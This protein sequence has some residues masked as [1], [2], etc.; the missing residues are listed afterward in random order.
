MSNPGIA[1]PLEVGLNLKYYSIL[2][3][4]VVGHAI[5]VQLNLQMITITLGLLVVGYIPGT[6]SIQLLFRQA[7]ILHKSERQILSV[8]LSILLVT[9]LSLLLNLFPQGLRPNIIYLSV[10][11]LIVLL[12]TINLL[13]DKYRPIPVRSSQ[14]NVSPFFGWAPDNLPERRLLGHFT[15]IVVAVLSL[16]LLMYL[17]ISAENAESYS[18][19]FV[20]DNSGG[21]NP[22]LL[23]LQVDRT[24]EFV[25][26]ISNQT[27]LEQQYSIGA[28][29]GDNL[30]FQ[31]DSIK[32]GMGN[33]E[34]ILVK[35]LI[36][37][38]VTGKRVQIKLFI[39]GQ[40]DPTNTLLLQIQE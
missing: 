11:F 2:L 9:T 10:W 16:T 7:N 27:G 14:K 37:G 26:G 19:F 4:V 15:V 30:L 28:S 6:L 31:S 22:G 29:A 32:V 12:L 3:L 8:V 24:N 25:L 38:D 40:V 13:F 21:A 18:E 33:T 36:P 20:L 35:L 34:T 1:S 23:E 17:T 39:S 5:S